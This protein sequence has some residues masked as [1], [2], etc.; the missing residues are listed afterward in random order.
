MNFNSVE[1]ELKYWKNQ[2]NEYK[3]YADESRSE[4]EEYRISS[5]E[6]ELELETQL[7]KSE[8]LNVEL[9]SVNE[10]LKNELE[11]TKAQLISVQQDLHQ[12]VS[13]LQ[14]ELLE[15]TSH[16]NKL[17]EYIRELE[18]LNDD[19]ERTKRQTVVSLE[20]FERRLNEAIE[21]NAFLESELEEKDALATTVQRLKDETRDLCQELTVRSYNGANNDINI[22][23]QPQHDI[24]SES[25][26]ATPISRRAILTSA[27]PVTS[28]SRIAALNI[29][30]D[31]LHRV[32]LL[33]AKLAEGRNQ[34]AI[35]AKKQHLI[36]NLKGV[37][38]NSPPDS[39][40]AKRVCEPRQLSVSS[41]FS[42]ISVDN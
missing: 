2:A 30:G 20:E 34:L 35:P 25:L 10:K 5:Q 4:L 24:E 42:N 1:E 3:H 15:V 6:L 41:D 33:E 16:R 31:L 28:S 23:K 8:K 37:M 29:V 27:T 40:R 21:R 26:V 39:P 12:Q 13:K 32:G 9:R 19:L 14:N 18:Q 22:L 38:S 17:T 36:N 7:E 11:N